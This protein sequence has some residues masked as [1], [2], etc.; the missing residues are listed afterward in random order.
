M[1]R[2]VRQTNVKS[3]RPQDGVPRPFSDFCTARNLVLLGD[4]GAGKSYLFKEAAKAEGARYITARAFLTTPASML[5]EQAL[6]VDALD[7]KRAGRSDRDT[8][9]AIGAKLFEVNPS[10]ARIACRVADWL[11]DSDLA[12]LRPYFDQHGETPVLLL[13]GLSREEQLVVLAARGAGQAAA[14][15][16]LKEAIERDLDDFLENPQ[17]LIMLWNA[18]KAGDWPKTRK[19]LF[20]VFTKL[21][22]QE[23]DKDRARAGSGA[24]SV[25]ELRPVAGAICAARLISDVEAISLTDQEGTEDI[26]GYRSMK[27]FS[28]EK[29]Q[30]TLGR[31]IF[32]AGHEPETV[33]YSHRTTAEYVAAEY[34]AGQI[35][36]GL[37][38][39][40]VVA[41]LGV[42]GHPAAELRGLHAWLAVH[43]PEH[44][45]ALIEADPYGVLTYG[46]ASSLTPSACEA[47]VGA[48]ARLSKEN[49]WFRSGNWQAR[50]V[51]AL[52]RPDMVD[53][54]RA[55]LSD[56]ASGF[57]IR[58]V[59][60]DALMLGA[61]LPEMLTDLKEVLCREAS[62][63]AERVHALSALLRLGDTGK[64]AICDAVGNLEITTNG[65]RLRAEVVTALY[66]DPYTAKDV[67]ALVNE[68]FL[69]R[70]V[71][72]SGLF[73]Q[74][75][76]KLPLEDLPEI[77][78][79]VSPPERK[80]VG[81][82]RRH[83][84]VGSL[85]ARILVRAWQNP[86]P[87]DPARVLDWLR[88]RVIFKDGE[89]RA[90]GLRAAMQNTPERLTEIA[91][92]FFR[93]VP[94]DEQRWLAF[95]RFR[96]ALLFELKADAMLDLLIDEFGKTATGSDRRV[97]YYEL[98]IALCYQGAE[99]HVGEVFAELYAQADGDEK[100]KDVLVRSTVTTL[101][102]DYLKGRSSRKIDGD[103]NR[104]RQ[105]RE[106]DDEVERITSGGH[107][108]WLEHLGRIYFAQYSDTDRSIA[109][110]ERISAWLGEERLAPALEALKASLARDDLPG[111]AAAMALAGEHKH[112]DWWFGLAAGLNERLVTGQTF[113][114]LSED[115]LKAMLVFDLTN[116]ISEQRD[117]NER[118]VVQSWRSALTEQ[119]PDLVR[120][121]YLEVVRLRLS[122]DDQFTDGLSDLL[123]DTAFAASRSDIV[124]SLLEDYPS[125]QPFRLDELLTA[126]IKLP[127]ARE[128]L[129]ALTR[130]VLAGSTLGERQRDLWLVT[131]FVLDPSAFEKDV[132]DRV[133][134]QKAFIFDL[135]D[136]SGFADRGQPEEL[137][138]VA[139]LELM[140]Q[141][142]GKYFADTAHPSGGWSG[143]T[144]DWDAAEWVRSLISAIAASPARAATE[145]LE[146]LR[147]NNE[148]TSYKPNILHAL[149]NQRQRRRDAEY[150]RPDWAQTLAALGNG[151]PATVAD[152][153]ALLVDHLTDLG[154]RIARENTDIFKQFWNVDSFGKPEKPRPEE[155]C[156]DDVV[157]LMRPFLLPLGIAVEPEGHMV[158][159][160][161]ADISVAMP[162]RKILCELKRDYHGE[163]WTALEGQLERFYA[164]D[165]DAKGFGIYCVFWFGDKRPTPIPAP[166]KGISRPQSAAEMQQMLTDL[167]PLDM[168][169]RIAVIVIDVSGKV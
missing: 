108:G 155:A 20:E 113:A 71:D 29:V 106:F 78:D 26:P 151:P 66:G 3:D 149:A 89:G 150:D 79:G 75:G 73:W 114:G 56:S 58:S 156:R 128:R 31:R 38:L 107:V 23:T 64:D 42:D 139:V 124:F 68:S 132:T 141:L 138:P 133:A 127:S 116:P 140:A 57:G 162:S 33:D 59:V 62:S 48:L 27:L 104:E 160:K 88:K 118:W 152:L 80:G 61:P 144:N 43:L 102:D 125:V 72:G 85:Y 121:T 1:T 92:H 135:R 46:D 100:L 32:D 84:E 69:A 122:K 18:V 117:G 39:G 4:P 24:L 44:A 8:V 9:D 96:E 55:I 10:K 76:D 90:R 98:A 83:W 131:G 163:V 94:V 53:K 49:P 120:D 103:T 159:D 5:A 16:F 134:T 67:I 119:R 6:F 25:A 112:Y 2:F 105:R 166:P 164:H 157:T 169:Q 126:A 30:A 143:N 142:A 40:R 35:R 130:K 148:L 110:R 146:R 81:F 13:Q 70:D 28:P 47:L 22:L 129:A 65:I 97:F 136:K 50:A 147:D 101:P 15:C 82:D 77:L 14:D 91:R 158:A 12:S 93:D 41:L 154:H 137:P 63:Y 167:T 45:E 37:P 21:L 95:S 153:H 54:F 86:Q 165:P 19:E 99:P 52:A 115:F 74:L 34:L 109:P 161:R 111:F 123:N 36:A 168:R 11:G 145:A 51:G 7:E 87:L 17:N 60:I